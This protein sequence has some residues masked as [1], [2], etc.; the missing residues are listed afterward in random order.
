MVTRGHGEAE[1][2]ER[3]ESGVMLGTYALAN[4]PVSGFPLSFVSR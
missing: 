1:L 4:Y 2:K 3:P